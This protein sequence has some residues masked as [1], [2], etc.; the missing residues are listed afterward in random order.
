MERVNIRDS[1]DFTGLPD[2]IDASI[3]SRDTS[4]SL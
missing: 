1:L 4:I 2:E 3:L